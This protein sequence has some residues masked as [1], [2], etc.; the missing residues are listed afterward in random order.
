MFRAQLRFAAKQHPAFLVARGGLKT[1]LP[2]PSMLIFL[3]AAEA[4]ADRYGADLVRS[5]RAKH[6]QVRC[7]GLGGPRMAEA[8]CELFTDM[9]HRSAMLMGAIA[10]IPRGLLL[11]HR[12]RR[13]FQKERPDCCVFLDSPF[14]N[15]RLVQRAKAA[16]ARTVYYIA[17]QT[18]AWH[19]S[20]VRQIRR[21]VDELA[22]I[23]PFE[24]DYFRRHGCRATFVGHPLFESLA[25]ETPDVQTAAR[26]RAAGEPRIV[27][28]PGSRRHVVQE[29]LPGQL[30]VAEELVKRFPTA[31]LWLACANEGLRPLVEGLLTR[32]QAQAEVLVGHNAALLSGADLALVASGTATL[33]AA[34]HA[35]PMVILYN[36]TPRWQWNL[37]GRHLVRTRFLSLVN[38]LSNKE[39]CPEFM[40]YYPGP[41]PVV[42]AAC[43]WLENPSA[44]Q[45]M[46][47]ELQRLVAPLQVI[48]VSDRVADIVL[49]MRMKVE[50]R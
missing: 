38:I 3:S 20:R 29:V 9:T 50:K 21:D 24:E 25:R 34:H 8:G 16:G 27:L 7:V 2:Y 15:L 19:E 39:L 48:G 1:Q 11:L 32:S 41:E 35:C 37:V 33:E 43:R 23:L 13:F 42:Q 46:R 47:Q 44:N 17:P 6:P 12:C 30:E 28:L 18:W 49:D 14:L 22:C 45:Q 36:S 31:S 5:L 4:S 26:L 10:E 40:P